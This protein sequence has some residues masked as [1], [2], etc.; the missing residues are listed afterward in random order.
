MLLLLR[1]IIFIRIF[2]QKFTLGV[3]LNSLSA[4]S[5]AAAVL[6]RIEVLIVE[7]LL[8]VFLVVRLLVS[9]K[10]KPWKILNKSFVLIFAKF[11][12]W[13]RNRLTLEFRRL[14]RIAFVDAQS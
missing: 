10:G 7:V 11:Q 4:T 6:I 8:I 9:C 13:A 14:I 12:L 2:L 3:T 5:E 1:V